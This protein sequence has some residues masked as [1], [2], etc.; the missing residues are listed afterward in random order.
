M[1]KSVIAGIVAFVLSISL[2]S[3]IRDPVYNAVPYSVTSTLK[4]ST[5]LFV[6]LKYTG[7]SLILIRKF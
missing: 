4:N 2:F 1:N 5:G 3:V 7:F 6:E